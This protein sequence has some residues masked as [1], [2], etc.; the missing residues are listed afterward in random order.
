MKYDIKENDIEQF[1][2]RLKIINSIMRKK[3][4]IIKGNC[5]DFLWR[6]FMYFSEIW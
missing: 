5:N 1:R 2:L 6:L 3:I 4:C